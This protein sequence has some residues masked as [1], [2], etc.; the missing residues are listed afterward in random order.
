[1]D[2]FLVVLA[3]LVPFMLVAVNF[4]VLPVCASSPSPCP[5]AF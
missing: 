4:Y 5:A 3:V 2:V 1:M